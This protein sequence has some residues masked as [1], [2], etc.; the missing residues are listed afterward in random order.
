M[1]DSAGGPVVR[2]C[3]DRPPG[4]AG[5]YLR[6]L[7]D[8]RPGRL[9]PGATSPRI[10]G[11]VHEARWSESQL[12]RYLE[13]CGFARAP[14]L[15][16]PFPHVVGS[17]LH[18]R[19]L[20]HGAFPVRLPGLVHV[21]HRIRQRRPLAATERFSMFC[22]IEGHEETDAGAEF[23]LHTQ[24]LSGDGAR[25]TLSVA[26]G[27]LS[28]RELYLGSIEAIR[29]ATVTADGSPG[30]ATFAAKANGGWTVLFSELLL[31]K[32]GQTLCIEAV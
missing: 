10:E 25:C 29:S 19:M 28:L 12:R 14:E 30:P 3:H 22:W 18:L 6:A 9:R 8:R 4:S 5:A 32:P 27:E 16:L 11:R 24:L 20:L 31:L 7:I 26:Y 23:C 1:P 2:L 21:W 13:V 15:P 17:G